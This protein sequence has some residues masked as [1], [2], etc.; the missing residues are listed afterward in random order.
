MRVIG[1]ANAKYE[2][3]AKFET[4]LAEAVRFEL[5]EDS[6]PRQFSRLLHSTALPRFQG[7]YFNRRLVGL[8]RARRK[9]F[10]SGLQHA[11]GLDE[12]DDFCQAGVVPQS[13]CN[14]RPMTPA[15][16]CSCSAAARVQFNSFSGGRALQLSGFWFENARIMPR[17]CCHKMP[18][19]CIATR[20]TAD[21]S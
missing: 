20:P 4:C 2:W 1:G 17:Q 12:G 6:H 10:S 18:G 9:I 3:S 7:C 16:I 14:L 15:L 19:I 13:S 8:W 5:T 21:F 11:F